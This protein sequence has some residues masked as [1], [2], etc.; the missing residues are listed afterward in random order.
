MPATRSL[1]RRTSAI[2][3]RTRSPLAPQPTPN[4]VIVISSDDESGPPPKRRS[5]NA[6]RGRSKQKARVNSHSGVYNILSD[7]EPSTH[8]KAS[9][10]SKSAIL[11]LERQLKEAKEVL[12]TKTLFCHMN[13]LCFLCHL[14]DCAITQG[15]EFSVGF[16]L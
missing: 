4:E 10:S 8:R 16:R 12:I 7:D 11:S 1:S 5:T 15:G 13:S 14:G 9:S 3:Q 6:D 2:A